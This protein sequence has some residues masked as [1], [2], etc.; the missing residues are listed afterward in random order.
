VA[1]G[2]SVE[3]DIWQ[4]YQS[5]NPGQV[6]VL[7]PDLFNGSAALLNQFKNSTGAT[8]PLLLN[9]SLG[10]GNE[11][12]YIPY[13]D[14]D[15]YA[16]INKAG[17]VRYHAFD[18]WPYGNR[19]HLNELRGCI[20]SLVSAPA[21]V[22]D[23]PE[24]SG[25]RLTAA[26]N[27]F[28]GLTRLELANPTGQPLDAILEVFDLAGRRVARL[29]NS[30]APPGVTPIDW[31]GAREGGTRLAPGVYLVRARIVGAQLSRRVLLIP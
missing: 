5:T 29:W 10:S 12:L 1:D 7:G 16:V 26:P 9:G 31:N 24:P 23:Q 4:H 25:F 17:I 15:N 28:R 8:F 2:P 18:H 14:R 3:S 21:A 13:G 20:D 22:G 27:P 11:D 19:Y 6:V 30:P